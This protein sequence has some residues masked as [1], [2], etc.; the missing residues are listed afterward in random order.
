MSTSRIVIDS[1]ISVLKC[2]LIWHLSN[3]CVGKAV[4]LS[5]GG[6]FDHVNQTRTQVKGAPTN[7]KNA[8]QIRTAVAWSVSF[9][10]SFFQIKPKIR[11]R[12]NYC[13]SQ[14]SF[15]KLKWKKRITTRFFSFP[16]YAQMNNRKIGLRAF[17]ISSNFDLKRV[18]WARNDCDP[19]VAGTT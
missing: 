7:K 6:L 11:K 2:V 5:S 8:N 13:F 4:R 14:Y 3:G 12:K 10:H 17:P 18:Q 19:E 9:V 15:T 1:H 16:F